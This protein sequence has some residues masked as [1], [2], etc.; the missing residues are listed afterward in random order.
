MYVLVYVPYF[1]ERRL[2][3]SSKTKPSLEMRIYPNKIGN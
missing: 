3:C 2:V 1:D